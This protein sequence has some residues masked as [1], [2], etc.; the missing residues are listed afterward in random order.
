MN[1]KEKKKSYKNVQASQASKSLEMF[2]NKM[3]LRNEKSFKRLMKQK[4]IAK[5]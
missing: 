2:L 3:D 5:W 1:M 4:F